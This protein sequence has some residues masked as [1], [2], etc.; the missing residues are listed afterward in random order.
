VKYYIDGRPIRESAHSAKREDAETLLD[1]RRGQRARGET[2]SPKAARLKVSELLDNLERRYTID[3]QT[4]PAANLAR[5]RTAF[6]SQRAATVT[7]ADWN[8]YVEKYRRTAERPAGLANGTL[9]RDLGTLRRAFSL[10]RQDFGGFTTRIEF[11]ALAEAAPRSGFFEPEQFAAVCRHLPVDLRPVA[12]FGYLTGW[13]RGEVLE[14]MWPRVS[15]PDG[16]V[17]LD[18]GTTK[19]GEG[20]VFPFTAELRALLEAQ[21]A[22]TEA[23]QRAKGII[24]PH[25]FHRNGRPILDFRKAWAAACK[26]AGVPGRLFHDFRRSAVRRFEQAGI[27]RATAM[28]GHKTENVYRRYAIVS[29]KDLR[30]AATLSGPMGTIPGHSAV[31]TLRQRDA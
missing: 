28:T 23:V 6:G 24:I 13:R 4:V 22:T 19:N 11:E 12:T 16:E 20:R 8:V 31:A 17:R 25:V 15:F 10:A 3:G 7:G 30:A 14:L 18:P 27:P 5:L 9:N 2:V 29:D 26:A 1:T 21:R